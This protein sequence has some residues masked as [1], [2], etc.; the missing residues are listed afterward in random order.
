MERMIILSD[1]IIINEELFFRYL[2]QEE[3]REETDGETYNVEEFKKLTVIK[4]YAKH[5]SSRA[6]ARCMGISQSTANLLIN[7]YIKNKA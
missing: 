2:D 6:V 1:G 5:K 7:K 3:D 4:L